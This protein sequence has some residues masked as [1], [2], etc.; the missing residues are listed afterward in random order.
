MLSKKV[1]M[2]LWIKWRKL[3]KSIITLDIWNVDG[4][5]GIED[6]AIDSYI[7]VEIPFNSLMA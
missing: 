6:G 2:V 3:E 4:A 7:K 5:Q 1:I